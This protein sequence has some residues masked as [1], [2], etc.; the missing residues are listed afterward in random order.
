MAAEQHRWVVDSIEEYVVSIEVDGGKM[1]QI[2]QWLVPDA[3]REGDVLSVHH[4]RPSNGK[5][6]V[7]R[8]E[9]D[10][11]A[12]QAAQAK[13]AEQVASIKRQSRDKGG[14]VVL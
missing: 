12:T 3:A 1:L 10:A 2:P 5:T 7:L 4:D 11:G 9:V 14:D 8:I 6:S 13:S